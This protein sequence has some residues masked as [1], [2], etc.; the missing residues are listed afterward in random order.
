MWPTDDDDGSASQQGEQGEEH[1][2]IAVYKAVQGVA[3][4]HA[5]DRSRGCWQ[6]AE[7]HKRAVKALRTGDKEGLFSHNETQ[8]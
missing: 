3:A 8:K 5:N 2:L 1:H 4:L 7:G 6:R